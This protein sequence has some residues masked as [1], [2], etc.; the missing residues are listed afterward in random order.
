M[1]VLVPSID[2]VIVPSV[3]VTVTSKLHD[4]STSD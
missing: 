2:K 4:E 3:D 1:G